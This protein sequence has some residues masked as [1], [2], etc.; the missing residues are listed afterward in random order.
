MMR[1]HQLHEAHIY[2]KDIQ[3][4]IEH[5]IIEKVRYGYYQQIDSEN[6]SEA[7]TVTRLFPDAVMCMDTALFYYRYSDRTPMVWHLAV[8]KDSGK[9]R[10][11]IDYPFVKPYYIEP[12][13]LELG[14]T[15]GEIDR[16]PVRI[17]NKERT[18]CDCLRYSG[19]MDKEI[20]KNAIRRYVED[21]K[22]DIHRLIEYAKELH[23][24]Q[25]VKTMI[26]VW[27]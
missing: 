22:K 9:S 26:G 23:V 1:T 27:I 13:L 15:D 6:L 4:L 12:F 10:F 14:A 16:N 11:K 8:S 7:A 21:P 19:K 2:Y 18:V 25:K 20:F 3:S 24:M 17:Y 5:G